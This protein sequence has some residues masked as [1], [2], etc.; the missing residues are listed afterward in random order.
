M[1]QNYARI[2]IGLLAA[3]FL[4]V[5]PMATA[6]ED[7]YPGVSLG[8][9][10][11]PHQLVSSSTG[12]PLDGSAPIT[13]SAGA[14]LSAVANGTTRE[15]YLVCV[16]TW[17]PSADVN[18]DAAFQQAQRDATAAAEAESKAWAEAHPGQQKCIQ[19]GPIVHANGVSTSS[20]GVCANPVPVPA[21]AVAESITVV[22]SPTPSSSSESSTPVSSP[23][24]TPSASPSPAPV[25]TNGFGGYAVVHPDGH[26][27]GVIVSGS[28]DPFNNGGVMPQEYMGCPSGSRIVFQSAPSADGNVAGWHGQDVVLSGDTYRLPGGSTINSGIVT[29]TNGR[30]W[31]SGTGAVISPGIVETTTV[32][33]DTSTVLS[34][35]STVI[36]SETSTVLAAPLAIAPLLSGA[37]PAT[38]IDDLD[39]LPEVEA[40]EEV[41]N[42]VEAKIVSGKTRIEIS[43]EWVDT[44]LTIVATKK[45]SKKKYTYK[46]TTNKEGNYLFKSSVNLKGFTL[47]LLK[48]SEELDREIV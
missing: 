28:S 25:N 41:S 21:G 40:V 20:G 15:N 11:G 32:R 45:G 31:N 8:A 22:S 10:V 47:V 48:G 46:V 1:K 12:N 43:T 37:D 13:C 6:E 26:V 35:T 4:S 19:W 3:L 30:T 14:G 27:C 24:P 36:V 23:T 9:E 16:K 18:A 39:G 42:T 5:A 38:P 34:E 33:S 17:R 29:D 2:T 44:R 7:P